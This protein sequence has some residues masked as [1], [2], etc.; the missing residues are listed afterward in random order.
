MTPSGVEAATFRFVA[1]HCNH[2]ATAV[3]E[4]VRVLLLY[5]S[6]VLRKIFG[7]TEQRDGTWR[8]KTNEEFDELIWHKNVINHIKAQRLS[9]FGHLHRMPEERMEKEV[10]KWK[11]TSIRLLGRPKNRWENDIRDD[12][13][14]SKIKNW[15][16]CTQD[17]NKW[18]IVRWEG[19]QT[20]KDWSC[21]AWRK[22]GHSTRRHRPDKIATAM[23]TRKK[24]FLTWQVISNVLFNN[25]ASQTE[26]VTGE[27][28]V[29]PP[30]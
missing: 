20:F 11:P 10:Y 3:S 12:T 17:R 26:F 5:E 4:R 16:S 1:Q 22:E 18:E 19:P 8:I 9:W 27:L 28:T 13:K 21:S 25:A 23:I 15:I 14:K 30:S 6:A 29:S 2:C 7:P 24:S